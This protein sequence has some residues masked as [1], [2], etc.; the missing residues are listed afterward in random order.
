ME[1]KIARFNER[2]TVQ[3][4]EVVADRYG[5]H[6]NSWTDYYS[7]HTYASTYQYDKEKET[8][9]TSEEQMPMI[10]SLWIS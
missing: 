5:N 3:K 1:R 6:R 4:N 8:A 9:I 2:L 10:S 7:C